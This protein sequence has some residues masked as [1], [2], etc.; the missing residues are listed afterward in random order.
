MKKTH[1]ISNL[2]INSNHLAFYFSSVDQVVA[3]KASGTIITTFGV[4]C[5]K[6]LAIH[7]MNHITDQNTLIYKPAVKGGMTYE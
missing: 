1:V 3:L 6:A 4:R 5:L 7:G 2:A